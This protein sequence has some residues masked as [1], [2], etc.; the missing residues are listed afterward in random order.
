VIE[1]NDNPNVE[2]GVEDG[3]LGATLY[4]RI[5]AFLI[6]RIEQRRRG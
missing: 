3:V 1:V 2:A 6:V 5:M 4:E